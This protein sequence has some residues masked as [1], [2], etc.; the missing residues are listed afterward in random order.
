MPC[1]FLKH[2][3]FSRYPPRVSFVFFL[4][5]LANLGLNRNIHTNPNTNKSCVLC[6]LVTQSSPTLRPHGLQPTRLPHPCGFSR[7]ETWSG[8]PFPTP[9]D[10]PNP[11]IEPRCRKHKTRR[12]DPW[13]RKISWSRKWHPTPVFLPGK[14]RGQR[15]L[16]GHSPWGHRESDTTE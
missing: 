6:V 1:A 3:N 4:L 11:G 8:L 15:S 9:G 7:Q 5:M 12:F 10:L 14:S 13:V 2:V 16:V